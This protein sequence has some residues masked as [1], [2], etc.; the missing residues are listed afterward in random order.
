VRGQAFNQRFCL[1][2][3]IHDSKDKL[4]T[5][6][7]AYNWILYHKKKSFP[8]EALCDELKNAY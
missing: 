7:K 2:F 3:D 4:Q 1:G 6:L 5:V 8:K